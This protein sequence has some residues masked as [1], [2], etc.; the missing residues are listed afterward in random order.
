MNLTI[1]HTIPCSNPCLFII[2]VELKVQFK[3]YSENNVNVN[4]K[5]YCSNN[6]AKTCSFGLKILRNI[7]IRFLFHF[8]VYFDKPDTFPTSFLSTFK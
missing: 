4:V 5:S 6:V 8:K 7:E 3:R 1:S 2:S